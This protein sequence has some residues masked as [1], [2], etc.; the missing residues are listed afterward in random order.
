MADEGRDNG[1]KPNDSESE[2]P[3]AS[4]GNASNP[5]PAQTQTTRDFRLRE[6]PPLTERQRREREAC[7]DRTH[8][9]PP[10]KEGEA[11]RDLTVA[12]NVPP[13]TPKAPGEP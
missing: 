11:S 1:K 2:A 3:R 10:L 5:G 12:P 7:I 9:K 6:P 4:T 13:T 8:K